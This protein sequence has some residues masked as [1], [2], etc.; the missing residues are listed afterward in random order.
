MAKSKNTK[1][2]TSSKSA[3]SRREPVRDF[4]FS[5]I[6]E[7][8]QTPVFLGIILILILIFFNAGLFGGKVFSSA[9]NIASN[10]FTTYLDDAKKWKASITLPDEKD[11]REKIAELVK[12]L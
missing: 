5:V 1:K 4:T 3:V 6:P 11:K 12:S 7:K 8:Y 2:E 9:D 10:S